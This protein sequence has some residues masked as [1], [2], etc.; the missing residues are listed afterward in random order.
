M[1]HGEVRD[2]IVEKVQTRVLEGMGL[3]VLHSATTPRS[4]AS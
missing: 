3:I 1:A 4:S 2:E